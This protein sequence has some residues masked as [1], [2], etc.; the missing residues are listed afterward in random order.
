MIIKES[1]ITINT[2][3]YRHFE[4]SK[5]K[6]YGTL[7]GRGKSVKIK[8]EEIGL[9]FKEMDIALCISDLLYLIELTDFTHGKTTENY[10][11]KQVIE[12]F[13]KTLDTFVLL[14]VLKNKTLY[15]ESIKICLPNG[16]LETCENNL[17]FVFIVN[18]YNKLKTQ[19]QKPFKD[20]INSLIS[21][22]FRLFDFK[23]LKISI[24]DY[25]D[26]KRKFAFVN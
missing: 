2:E 7:S 26:A 21:A 4:I 20:K 24:I 23:N 15:S 3:N 1:G 6:A 11:N 16:F 5:C 8:G 13:K 17:K 9:G 19:H 10:I 22:Y 14:M 12:F 25:D 18:N